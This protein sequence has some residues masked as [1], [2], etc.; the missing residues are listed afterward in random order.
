MKKYLLLIPVLAMLVACEDN[1][2][3]LTNVQYKPTQTIDKTNVVETLSPRFVVHSQGSFTAG[4]D[5]CKREILIVEDTQEK[6]SYL[7]ITDCSLIKL[8][9]K[10]KDDQAEAISDAVGIAL[11]V[12]FGD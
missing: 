11:D 3:E 4:Y 12:A 5:N 6:V 7:A 1:K 9:Q 8:V 2:Q 10:K